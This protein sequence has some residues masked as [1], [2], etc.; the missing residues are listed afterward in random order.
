LV[1]PFNKVPSGSTHLLVVIDK[2]TKWIEDKP[3]AKLKSSETVAFF[4]D[5]VYRFGVPNS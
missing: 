2:F 5:I 3:I 1:G 4:Y